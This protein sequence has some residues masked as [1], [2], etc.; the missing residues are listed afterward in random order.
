MQN[1]FYGANNRRAIDPEARNYVA[2]KIGSTPVYGF[3]DTTM[4]MAWER[5]HPCLQFRKTFL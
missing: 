2:E 1:P 4:K 5:R 3:S